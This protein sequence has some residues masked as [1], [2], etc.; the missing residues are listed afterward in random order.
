MFC[1]WVVVGEEKSEL[2]D[3]RF[4]GTGEGGQ[5]GDGGN[6]LFGSSII[7]GGRLFVVHKNGK[8]S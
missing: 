6:G 3:G 4:P 8:S 1:S 5:V 7:K 2:G